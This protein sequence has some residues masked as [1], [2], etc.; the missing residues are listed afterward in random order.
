MEKQT[1]KSIGKYLGPKPPE[2]KPQQQQQCQLLKMHEK[3]SRYNGCQ[4]EFDKGDSTLH[5]L[6]GSEYYWFIHVDRKENI[7]EFKLS[8]QNRYYIVKKQCI[9][10]YQ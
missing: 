9:R 2:P 10:P 7:K 3:I 8:R 6:G 1:P 5:I 4:C